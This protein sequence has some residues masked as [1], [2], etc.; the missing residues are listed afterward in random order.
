MVSSYHWRLVTSFFQLFH[1][2]CILRFTS[3][4]EPLPFCMVLPRYLNSVTSTSGSW[5]VCM[6]S[7]LDIPFKN[8]F[9]VLVLETYISLFLIASLQISRSSS[10]K[11]L[12]PT[13]YT[14]LSENIICHGVSFLM[15]SAKASIVMAKRNELKAE[16]WWSPTKARLLSQSNFIQTKQSETRLIFQPN[17]RSLLAS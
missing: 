11:S 9:F 1:S 2:N 4:S 3:A 14:T 16:P 6:L 12:S 5:K 7:L 8:F 10:S 13:R 17:Y 15:S